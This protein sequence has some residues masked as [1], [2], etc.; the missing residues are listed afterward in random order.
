MTVLER[1]QETFGVQDDILDDLFHG[2]A[3]AAFIEQARIE[4]SWPDVEKT[5]R[6]A[7]RLYEQSLRASPLKKPLWNRG[8]G[9][10]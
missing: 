5:R 2:C 10:S 4:D 7:Y 8:D 1:T 9:S 3:W 6:I